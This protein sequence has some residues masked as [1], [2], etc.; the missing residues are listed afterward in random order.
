[1]SGLATF[2]DV[3]IPIAIPNILTYRVPRELETLVVSGMRILVPLGKNKVQTAVVLKVHGEPPK[4]YEA[5]Y[6]DSVLDDV[7]VVSPQQLRFWLWM[8]DYYMCSVGEVAASALPAGLKL[9][10]ETKLVLQ[11]GYRELDM[12]ALTDREFLLIE[13][14]EVKGELEIKDVAELT[15]LKTV[16][17]IIKKL[18][19]K[20]FVTTLEELKERY[21]PKTADFVL[22]SDQYKDESQL[23]GLIDELER[24]A[25]KQ[26]DLLFAYFSD[27]PQ[28]VGVDKIQLQKKAGV[29][30][31]VTRKMVDKGV[32][33]LESRIVD[34]MPKFD[35]SI[36]QAKELNEDQLRALREIQHCFAED[37]ICLLHGVTG[38][39]KTEV[40]VQLIKEALALG[41]QVLYLLPEIALTTQLIQRL[42]LHF[43]DTVGVYHSKFNTHERLETWRKVMLN[44]G[45]RIIIGARSALFLP[46]RDLGLVIVDEEHES[47]FKQYDPAPR[48]QGRDAAIVLAKLYK[49]HVLLGS[50]TPS[51]ESYFN[52][53]QGRYGLVSL[54]KRYGDM[55]MPEVQ[56]ADVR[57]ETKKRTMRSHFTSFLI[58]EMEVALKAEKQIILFQNRRGY[59]PLW[60]CKTCGEVPQCTRCDVSLTYHK[61]E[62]KL[63]CHYCGFVQ[64]PP[65]K[66]HVCGSYD[67]RSVGFGTEKI[68][69][70]LAAL[71]PKAKIAR[72][73]LDTTRSKNAYQNILSDFDNGDI[74]ILVG[75]QMVTKGLDFEHVSLVGILNADQMLHF[76]DFRSFER[77]FQLM[78][79]VAGRAGRKHERGKVI[80]QTYQPDHTI[81]QHVMNHDYLAMY[82]QELNERRTYFYP[83]F[84][85]L[86]RINLR[87]KE[88]E[89]LI[90]GTGELASMLREK[91]GDRLIGPEKPYVSRINNLYHRNLLLKLERDASTIKAKE[92]LRGVIAE[93]QG[94][95]DRRAIRLILDVDPM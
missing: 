71:F 7:P 19:D 9:A 59:A 74:D 45:C 77:G 75:T 70:D 12:S 95:A 24:R 30:A 22:L 8:A 27:D 79:Q 61:K 35:G 85:R 52:A 25:P 44:D 18:I 36:E 16:Q 40:Y 92:V 54:H 38:S 51:I 21:T 63:S 17:P 89:Q 55:V 69:E 37:E 81:V 43:G 86:I 76:P 91:F 62:H 26:L 32:F 20:G 28:R 90:Q 1:M 80:I 29:D 64:P 13:A 47:S 87:H 48:Y 67:L 23:N 60:Q 50:A 94:N 93:F 88:E 49:A 10:S 82:Q 84:W 42:R 56:C 2:V 83:P 14:L 41:K 31:A 68:E 57:K 78:T 58:Q 34:R 5:K 66:C 3:I 39:G 46:F 72:M 65:G 6:I 15:G 11:V 73:D 33:I 53:T 4:A